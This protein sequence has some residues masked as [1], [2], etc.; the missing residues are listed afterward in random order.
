M[1]AEVTLVKENRN[2]KVAV[3]AALSCY[4]PSLVPIEAE[5]PVLLASLFKSGHH[6]TFQHRS[7]TFQLSGVSRYLVWALLHSHPFYNSSQVSQRYVKTDPKNFYGMTE[8]ANRHYKGAILDA[9]KAYQELVDLILPKAQDLY[10][11]R[12]AHRKG[13]AKYDKDPQKIAW[14]NAR[15]VLPLATT[16]HLYHTIDFLT[17][18]RLK[19]V[20]DSPC[21]APEGRELVDK[22]LKVVLAYD[23]AL[24]SIADSVEWGKINQNGSYDPHKA[25]IAN[26]EF[27]QPFSFQDEKFDFA[28]LMDYMPHNSGKF[29]RISRYVNDLGLAYQFN[30]PNDSTLNNDMTSRDAA[31]GE[32][33]I[34]QFA[35]KTSLSCD[36]QQQRHRSIRRVMPPLLSIMASK[37]DY[38][39][40]QIFKPEYEE[41]YCKRIEQQLRYFSTL[42]GEGNS[43]A[44][45]ALPNAVNVRFFETMSLNAFRHQAKMRLCMNA[46]EEI[47]KATTEESDQILKV[48]GWLLKAYPGGEL[49]PNCVRRFNDHKEPPCL[50]GKRWCGTQPW[51]LNI[52]EKFFREY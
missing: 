18:M 39:V 43:G 40:P 1:S 35:K 28:L 4:G 15:Y 2:S 27:D 38:Y 20:A 34:Y 25:D 12:F 16:C 42:A 48:H 46:Q 36:A 23:P 37:P 33:A 14:E 45:Y 41:E 17:L 5:N 51:R 3:A 6:T 24:R 52:G 31:I 44:V 49:I 10:Y 8:E 19:S 32:S 50:E 21:Y 9:V 47:W 13:D 22:M 7:Y 11:K 26:K 30:G 29:D